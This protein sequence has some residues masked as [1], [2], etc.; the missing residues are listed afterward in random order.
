MS[1]IVGSDNNNNYGAVQTAK[2]RALG[3]WIN[4]CVRSYSSGPCAT[5]AVAIVKNSSSF[6]CSDPGDFCLGGGSSE[7][8]SVS[9]NVTTTPPACSVTGQFVC[10]GTQPRVCVNDSSVAGGARWSPAADCT[11]SLGAGATCV[12]GGTSYAAN[13]HCKAAGAAC[14]TCN[15]DIR[16]KMEYVILL[17][18][19]L[20][21][22]IPVI[23]A[24]VL[25]DRVTQAEMLTATVNLRVD[26]LIVA[27]MLSAAR[28]QCN[29]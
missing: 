19:E 7:K 14:T 28:E 23:V 8:C 17:V 13:A 22:Q 21:K 20:A 25:L 3:D 27:I 6:S 4:T 26:M 10:N 11:T 12:A 1:Y 29:V 16:C 9:G 18:P 2:T 5:A 24:P 15:Q